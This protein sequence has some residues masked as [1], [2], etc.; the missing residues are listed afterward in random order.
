M[1]QSP[2]CEANRFLANK[3]I[4]CILWNTKIHY[5]AHKCPPPVP[6]LSQLDPVHTLTSR[7]L[8]IHLNIILP[9]ILGLQSGPFPSDFPIET[10]YTPVLS[11]IRTTLPSHLP[12]YTA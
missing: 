8:T 5:R 9:S 4:L 2:S 10:L 6:I 11:P 12:L 1:E 7:F 3:E